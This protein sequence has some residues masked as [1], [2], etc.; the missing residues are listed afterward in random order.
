MQKWAGL[1]S[2]VL[3]A[4]LIASRLI[5]LVGDL[6]SVLGPPGYSLADFLY[7]PVWGTALISAFY[8]IREHIGERAPRRVA[9]AL[10][11]ALLAAAAMT[12]VA[13]LRAANRQYHLIHPE[14]HLESSTTVLVVWTTLVAGV[15]AAAWHFLG[16]A[17][18]LFGSAGW[19]TRR[20]PRGLSLLYLAAAI[21]S[22]F[23]FASPEME[24][25]AGALSVIWAIWQGAWLWMA[26]PEPKQASAADSGLL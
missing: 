24:G 12:L 1:A 15:T 23:V 9:M 4:A 5:Y 2:F 17:L 8:V 3:A 21:A 18:L 11:A 7:G 6:R 20:L 14:L 22:L 10:Q 19:G 25:A 16:W 13:C 26:Q